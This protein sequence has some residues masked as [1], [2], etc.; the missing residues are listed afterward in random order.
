MKG[1]QKFFSLVV[2]V[3]C[4][5]CLIGCWDGDGGSNVSNPAGISSTLP[6]DPNVSAAAIQ[7][8][9][10]NP[11]NLPEY[12]ELPLPSADEPAATMGMGE[13]LSLAKSSDDFNNL[14]KKD[15]LSDATGEVRLDFY[16]K[17]PLL[18]IYGDY[19]G[20]RTVKAASFFQELRKKK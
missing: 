20:S 11:L 15:L 19:L 6:V 4:F 3:F 17:D 16:G 5:C 7:L 13:T 9:D 14:L 1:L 8:G 10:F 2:A 18:D 12:R